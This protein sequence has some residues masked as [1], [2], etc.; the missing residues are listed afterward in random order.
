M[1]CEKSYR[2]QNDLTGH[3]LGL[4]EG[5][6]DYKCKFCGLI[7]IRIAD[8]KKQCLYG[9]TPFHLACFRGQAELAEI[10]MK[11]SAKLIIDLNAKDNDGNTAF[12]FA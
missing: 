8:L 5:D 10:I 2:S 6:P 3:I 4:H 12:L 9:R 7:C 11:N 1:F